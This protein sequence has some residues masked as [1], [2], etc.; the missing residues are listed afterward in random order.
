VRQPSALYE[1]C[2]FSRKII[3]HAVWLCARSALSYHG[4]EELLAE[5]GIF[6]RRV[7]DGQGY[8]PRV[9]ITDKLTS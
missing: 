7:L 5:R 4:V 6:L 1:C 9:V 2:R 8:E 3:S